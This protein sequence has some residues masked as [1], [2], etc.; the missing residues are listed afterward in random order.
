M[1]RGPHDLFG[2]LLSNKFWR[3][4]ALSERMSKSPLM[5]AANCT[6]PISR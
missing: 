2:T 4:A 6:K 3:M 1:G 5:H